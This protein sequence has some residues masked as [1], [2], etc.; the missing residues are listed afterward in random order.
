MNTTRLEKRRRQAAK[1]WSAFQNNRRPLIYVG[2]GSCGLAAGAA[3][4]IGVME[5]YLRDKKIA[6]DIVRVGCIGP[7]YL[8][9]LV[10]MKMP[11]QARISYANITGD[12]VLRAAELNGVDIPSLCSHKDLSPFGG[13]RMCVVEIEGMRGYPL[14]CSTTVQEGMKVLTDTAVLRDMR[15]EVLRL[16][17]SEHPSSCLICGESRECR[18]NQFTIRKSG[19]GAGCRSCSNDGQCELQDIVEK[20]GLTEINY[21]IHY[22]GYE[23]EHDDPF[24]DRDY[25]PFCRSTTA[26]MGAAPWNWACSENRCPA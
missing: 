9:P 12:S 7:C 23:A 18:H 2:A 15:R 20:V 19:V 6:A 16:I 5:G 11:G 8:E 25:I 3:E 24:F 4:V 1:K 26:A 14:S 17:L 21:A 22:R 13:C 10:D